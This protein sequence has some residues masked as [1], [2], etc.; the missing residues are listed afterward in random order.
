MLFFGIL[1]LG[2]IS[3]TRLPTNLFPDIRAPKITVTVQ[4]EGLSPG[5]VERRI[6]ELL[7][8][9][10]FAIRGVT[11][12]KS[13]A[14]ADTAVIVVDFSWETRM[15]YA[16]LEVKKSASD[17]Q[18]ERSDDIESVEVLRY[19]P[20]AAPVVTAALTA[21]PDTDQES[22]L[23]T[24]EQSLKP[25][26]ERLEG[27]AN[28]VL[29]GG[30]EREIRISL[31]EGLLISYGLDT[32]NVINALQAE[33][34]DAA[35]G[36]VEEGTRRY[37]V[38][39]VGEFQDLDEVRRVVVG[40]QGEA[41]ILM[42]DV[43]DVSYAPKEPKSIVYLN[44]E[45]AV[46]MAFYREAES[47]TIAVAE[48]IREELEASEEILPKGWALTVASDDSQFI[49]DAIREV[50]NN[51][52]VGGMLAVL[53][54]LLFLRD[55]RTTLIVAVA[56]PVSIITTFNLMYFQ[57]LSLNLMTLGGLAL[58][59]GMLVDNAIVVLENIFRLR[60]QQVPAKEAAQ[61]G[62]QEVAGALIASTMTT[63]AVFL[64]IVYVQGI[65]ALLFR[66]Q[67]LTVAYSLAASLIV[68][69]L[70]IPLMA[71]YF[72]GAPPKKTKNA[73]TLTAPRGVY[74]T[75]LRWALKGRFFVIAGG[76]ALTYYAA[77]LAVDIPREFLPSTDVRQVTLR[78]TLPN[79][80]PIEAT[81]RVAQSVTTQLD[82]Y[83]PFI[84][85]VYTRTGEPEGVV[86]A[87]TEDPDGPNTAELLI[88]LKNWDDPT[89]AML[90]S[91]ETSFG[92]RK[93][94]A[95]M[96]PIVDRLDDV[97]AE[98]KTTQGSV[99]SLIGGSAA[100]LLVEISG[101]ELD[102]LTRL[103]EETKAR[104]SE[105][106]E[107]LNV[108]TNILQGSPEVRM[109]LDKVQLARYGLNVNSVAET[110]RQRIDGEVATQIRQE[111]GD[112][113]LRVEVDYGEESIE[114]LE[115]I[116]LK[117]SS[118]ALVRLG[119]VSTIDIVRGPREIVRE[120]QRRVA[121]A[122]ADLPEGVKLSDAIAA[123]QEALASMTIPRR[124]DIKFTG[125][126]EQRRQAFGDLQF[127]LILSIALVYM[128]MA[129]IFESFIQPFLILLTIPLAGIGIVGALLLT[130]QT[131]SVMSIIGVIMLGG[132]V[133]N[134]AIVLLDCVNQVRGEASAQLG[135]RD[136]LVIGCHRRLR[137]VL[138]TTATTMLGLTPMALGFG[139]G[140]ELRQA[141]A[142]AVL[143]GMLS[144][145]VL[146]LF[147]IPCCQSYLDSA[148]A[149]ARK[150]AGK[151]AT[152][153]ETGEE[154]APEGA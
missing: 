145:T 120:G 15:D 77:T 112:V 48:S 142:I 95:G 108:R 31:D 3:L 35:G 17:L 151:I 2:W 21:P 29:T 136:T 87:N 110:L 103:A 89:T 81:D 38:K 100:P 71:A 60:Q 65:A 123:S 53:V 1:L 47:N 129:S 139:E 143:G 104:L 137:P 84:E 40:G 75:M 127:A 22:V 37:L 23:K 46:G 128:V 28:V 98:F 50:S 122:M 135:E 93:L 14:R 119:A 7:E 67:G 66:E 54:L 51:A 5:E 19:D 99:G 150:A 91:G 57:G 90:E 94:I 18:R 72:L 97:K 74:P 73:E 131:F 105:A 30:M 55:L 58:G 69:L 147:F 49:A 36:W 153:A 70:L 132:I 39:T 85:T 114:M 26:F 141:M 8:R 42:D 92:S 10:L 13:I 44:G 116:T 144:S 121:Y 56:I 4:T 68:A 117:S 43:A 113:D 41:S 96:K 6:N 34:V 118:G 83:E 52:I 124:Y 33:N 115:G 126:E 101:P 106:P 140:A 24:A 102:V 111:S 63:V 146:T 9:S 76:V 86:N 149:L 27:V 148:M 107:L 45:P 82:R 59:T 16:F 133:V 134:N 62:S 61:R 125:E 154:P 25:R 20:N 152:K 32:S 79:G 130:G 64:P 78:L 88:S 80:T 11:G 12:V 109:Q 138:M